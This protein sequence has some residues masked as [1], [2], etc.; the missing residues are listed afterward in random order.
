MAIVRGM[1][2]PPLVSVVIP[3]RDAAP[4]LRR[5]IASVQAQD[6]RPLEIIVVDDAS[7]DGT[8]AVAEACAAEDPAPLRLL[9]HAARLGAAAARN[10]GIAAARGEIIAFQDADDEWLPGKLARQLALLTAPPPPVF[11]ACGCSFI[12]TE[13]RDLGP[14]YGGAVPGAGPRA[15]PGLLARNTIGTPSV[16]AWRAAIEAAGGF[17]ESLPVAEDQDLWIRLAMQGSLGYLDEPLV[18]V[19]ATPGSLSGVGDPTGVT[20][21]FAHTLPMILRHLAARRADLTSSE[22]RRI[23]GERFARLGRAA[24]GNGMHGRGARLLLRA[25]LQGF[26][27]ATNLWVLGTASPPARWLKRRFGLDRGTPTAP[28]GAGQ[29]RGAS[30]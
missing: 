15:W 8:A 7:R 1:N 14:L 6:W 25:S 13:G 5:A 3:A 11:V 19:H 18:R 24:Y 16:V 21:Q 10:G 23:L 26:E 12:D 2:P 20:Q 30:G 28:S 9:R 4:T 29:Q 22:R 17:D 27:P